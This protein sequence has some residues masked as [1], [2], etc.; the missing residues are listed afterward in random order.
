MLY[1]KLFSSCIYINNVAV[2]DGKSITTNR[3]HVMYFISV[4]LRLT[5]L[6]QR[7]YLFLFVCVFVCECVFFCE[8][9]CV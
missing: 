5:F 4:L 6:K 7:K 8:C 9:V 3:N 2:L 1:C